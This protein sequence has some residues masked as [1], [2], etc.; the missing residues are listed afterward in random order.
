MAEFKMN[1]GWEAEVVRAILPQ[2]YQLRDDIDVALDE[3]APVDTGALRS[4]TFADVDDTSGEVFVS[5]DGS[6]VNPRSK[7][8]VG[9]Y[10]HFVIEGTSERPANDYIERATAAALQKLRS[11]HR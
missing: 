2:M 7:Q 9:T 11:T 3:E 10:S 4:A 8:R 6:V 1:A 5:I